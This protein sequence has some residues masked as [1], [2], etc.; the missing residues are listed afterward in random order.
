MST[1]TTARPGDRPLE[2]TALA[3]MVRRLAAALSPRAIYLF[4]SHAYGTPHADSDI[5]LYVLLDTAGDAWDLSDAGY[6]ALRGVHLPVELHFST[7]A[8][9]VRFAGVVGSLPK[10]VRERGRLLFAA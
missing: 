9:F 6:R 7:V 8:D 1:T 5:D 10:E 2:E 3:E 4:G